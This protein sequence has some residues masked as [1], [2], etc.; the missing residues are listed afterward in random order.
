MGPTHPSNLRC[1]CRKNHLLKTF[2]TGPEGWSDV[3][4]PDGSITWTAPTGHIYTTH[5]GSRIVFPHWDTTNAALP[6]VQ[7]RPG[8]PAS[9]R[10]LQMPKRRRTRRAEQE[11]R[12]KRL[13]AQWDTS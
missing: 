10:G 3:Q 8:T 7:L 4:H 13:R 12:I 11:Q 1:L 6:E 2:Y 9:N 5:P